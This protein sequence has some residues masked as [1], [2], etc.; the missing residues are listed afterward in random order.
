[1]KKLF[2][3]VVLFTMVYSTKVDAQQNGDRDPAAMMQRMKERI[4]PSLIEKTKLTDAQADKVIEI[5]FSNQRKRRD[6][7]MDQTLTDEER[8]KKNTELLEAQNASLKAIP[9]TDD[10]VKD[11]NTFFEE[12]RKEQ[13]QRRQNSGNGGN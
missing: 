5:N 8:T 13:M 7:R 9:L 12:M 6:I 10:Q 2:F 1:M 11:V 3:L 4:K